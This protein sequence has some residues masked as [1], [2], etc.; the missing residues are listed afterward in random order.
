MNF[1]SSTALLVEVY[2]DSEGAHIN[3][4]LILVVVIF[5]TFSLCHY[6]GMMMPQRMIEFTLIFSIICL[7][8]EFC[9]QGYLTPWT[10]S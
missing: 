10:L 8:A 1:L 7:M 9:R 2:I 4:S 3:F 6:T 5:S